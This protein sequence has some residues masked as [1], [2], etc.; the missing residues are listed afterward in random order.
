MGPSR[1]VLVLEDPRGPICKSLS[2][3]SELKSSSLSLRFNFSSLSSYTWTSNARK[4]SRTEHLIYKV[5]TKLPN[6]HLLY[7][8]NTANHNLNSRDRRRAGSKLIACLLNMTST[9]MTSTN[10][11]LADNLVVGCSSDAAK[12]SLRH[13]SRVRGAFVCTGDIIASVEK[14]MYLFKLHALAQS[15]RF[16]CDSTICSATV[17]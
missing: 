16:F 4:L 6:F 12:T 1:K 2:L 15:S 7:Q 11:R 13:I 17:P 8:Q 9:N 5:I 14:V 3:S 10:T